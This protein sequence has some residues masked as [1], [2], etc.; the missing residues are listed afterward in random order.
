MD[1]IEIC[2]EDLEKKDLQERHYKLLRELQSMCRELPQVY[3]Q[4]LPNE[5]LSNLANS[6][7]DK[8]VFDIVKGLKDIQA[9]T[10]NNLLETRM[11]YIS[12]Q[13][14]QKETLI[15]KHKE[16]LSLVVNRRAAETLKLKQEK[17]LE[18]LKKF[19][20]E[21]L[22]RID[23]KII[24]ELDQVV[25]DQQNTLDRAGV[26]GFILSNKE[27]DIKLQMYLLGFISELSR[28]EDMES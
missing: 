8:T 21:E 19:Q 24:L 5:L 28:R 12:N 16:D 14:V 25:S 18:E 7:L 27:V 13:R 26:P 22:N 10:E 20:E 6:L 9:M 1:G 23:M 11:K 2:E 15:K 4:R 3:Q 17:E